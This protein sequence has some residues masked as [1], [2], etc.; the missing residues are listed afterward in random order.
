MAEADVYLTPRP[1]NARAVGLGW[2]R[3]RAGR[4]IPL[5]SATSSPPASTPLNESPAGFRD[6]RRAAE[7]TGARPWAAAAALALFF[8]S[9]AVH[10]KI[11]GYD[12]NLK[13]EGVSV[14]ADDVLSL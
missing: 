13:G 10:P 1:R 14:T 7:M 11:V 2:R 3:G 5:L 9:S 8:S 6:Q 12:M 4:G